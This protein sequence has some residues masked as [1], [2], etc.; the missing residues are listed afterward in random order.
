[1]L[2]ITISNAIALFTDIYVAFPITLTGIQV[3]KHWITLRKDL[4]T[5]ANY[6]IWVTVSCFTTYLYFWKALHS[7]YYFSSLFCLQSTEWLYSYSQKWTQSYFRSTAQWCKFYFLS[8]CWVIPKSLMIW[9][10]KFNSHHGAYA[11]LFVA[12]LNVDVTFIL[13]SAISYQL[14]S[15]T[16]CF[17]LYYV[18]TNALKN[19]QFSQYGDFLYKWVL[20]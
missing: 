6:S 10:N 15:V 3:C 2:Q 13:I 16:G 5:T 14:L 8:Y 18:C 9:F 7:V 19:K 12:M 1:M 4:K 11:L 20:K 17:V